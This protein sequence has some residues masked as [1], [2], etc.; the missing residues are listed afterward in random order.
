M[1]VLVVGAT[2]QTGRRI[3]NQLSGSD[4]AVKAMVRDRSKAADFSEAVEV[5]VG[6]VLKPETLAV[7]IAGCDAII[8]ATGAAPSF[9][10]TGPYQVDF[11]GTKNLVD[12]A[13]L[14]D[15]KRF[16]IVSS[17][18]VSKFFHPLNLFWLVLYWKKQAENYIANSGLTYTIVRPGGLRNEDSGDPILMASADTLF[19]GGIA[20]EKV[21][22]VCI[23]ALSEPESENKIVEIVMNS[24]A[25]AQPFGALFAGVR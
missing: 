22:Q 14:A 6:D 3:T 16:V 19:E 17:L 21:A 24:E 20:R 13:K 5:V 12:A 23:A 2:G 15:V 10:M 8:C 4:V 7:A 1:K 9:D 25:Q 11:V 18:C